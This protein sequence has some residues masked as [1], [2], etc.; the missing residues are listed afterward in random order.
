MS[1]FPQPVL[2]PQKK[3]VIF[4]MLSLHF[5]QNMNEYTVQASHQKVLVTN[6]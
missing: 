2:K 3:P 6:G 4:D 1:C 5:W